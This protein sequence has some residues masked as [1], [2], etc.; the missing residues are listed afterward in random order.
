MFSIDTNIPLTFILG[1]LGILSLYLI[2]GIGLAIRFWLNQENIK[3]S[4]NTTADD[5]ADI[6]QAIS[7]MANFELQLGLM[8]QKLEMVSSRV[9]VNEQ[10]ERD[11]ERRMRA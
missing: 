1:V 6:K 2:S 4:V 3:A 10:H 11:M 8:A 5:I 7:K 9:A